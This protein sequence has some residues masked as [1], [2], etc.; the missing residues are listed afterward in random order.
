MLALRMASMM[1]GRG[2]AW[3]EFCAFL[4]HD[5]GQVFWMLL[6]GMWQPVKAWLAV[7]LEQHRPWGA[8]NFAASVSEDA[9]LFV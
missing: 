3:W 8:S 4:C 5:E 7:M 6:I 2:S 1:V 9:C